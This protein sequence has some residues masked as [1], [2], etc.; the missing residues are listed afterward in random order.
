[1][2]LVKSGL[3]SVLSALGLIMIPESGEGRSSTVNFQ[4]ESDDLPLVGACHW[5]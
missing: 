2:A 1:M 4:D 5:G 3:T